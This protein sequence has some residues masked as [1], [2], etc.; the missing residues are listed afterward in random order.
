MDVARVRFGT[1]SIVTMTVVAASVLL[2]VVFIVSPLSACLRYP[3][4]SVEELK[5]LDETGAL[6]VVYLFEQSNIMAYAGRSGGTKLL[7]GEDAA[8]VLAL[9]L[10]CAVKVPGQQEGKPNVSAGGFAVITTALLALMFFGAYLPGEAEEDACRTRNLGYLPLEQGSSAG[11]IRTGGGTRTQRTEKS[12]RSEKA[13]N[14]SAKI[15]SAQSRSKTASFDEIAGYPATKKSLEFIVRCIRDRQLLAKA[16]AKIPK[17]I[18][19]YGPPGTGKTLMAAAVAGSAGVPFY[20]VNAAAFINTYVGT[21][22][23]A[24]RKLYAQA[25]ENAPCIVFIDELDAVGRRRADGDNAEYRNTTNAL[26]SELDGLCSGS[27]VLTIAATN[28]YE[29]LDEALTRS[30]R[31]DRKIEVPL[32]NLAD[33]IEILGLLCGNK[34]LKGDVDLV[35]LAKETEGMSGADLDTLINESAI[36]AVSQKRVAI[37]RRD[38]ERVLFRMLANSGESGSAIGQDAH[39]AAWHEA[40][41]A[42]CMRLLGHCEIHGLTIQTYTAGLGG[43]TLFSGSE[44]MFVSRREAEWKIMGLYAG[45][46]AEELLFGSAENVTSAGAGD[47]RQATI[48]IRE[49]LENYGF[50]VQGIGPLSMETLVGGGRTASDAYMKKAGALAARLYGATLAFLQEHRRALSA[51]AEALEA[52]GSLHGE[53]VDRLIASAEDGIG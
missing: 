2:W 25:R 46:A 50:D 10:A 39:A 13:S 5:E 36:E 15:R 32:P 45:R 42:V 43:A 35:M 21:G 29:A 47:I 22:P 11:R 37:T 12:V 20:S 6:R 17:G 26:L 24:V 27:G 30:G 14:E 4:G 1:K 51:V 41:H 19:L 28:A 38:I 53:E 31:F 8:A 33:R 18:I 49:Y 23:A 16:G 34:R 52:A 3:A 48:L 40:G 9:D 44:G 7:R